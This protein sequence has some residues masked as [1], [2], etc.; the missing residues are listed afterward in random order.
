MTTATNSTALLL[1]WIVTLLAALV[2]GMIFTALTYAQTK[3]QWPAAL[4]AGFSAAGATILGIHQ[5]LSQP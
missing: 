4:L 1:A 5:I 3:G 2:A